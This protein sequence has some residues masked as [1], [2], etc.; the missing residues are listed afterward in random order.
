MVLSISL[1]LPV[2]DLIMDD[3]PYVV[4]STTVL[5]CISGFVYLI[6]RQIQSLNEQ[7]RSVER[8]T[9]EL[10]NR[11]ACL[12]DSDHVSIPLTE[13]Q[14]RRSSGP[15]ITY[16]DVREPKHDEQSRFK[17]SPTYR[18]WL[19]R[20]AM[21]RSSI[22][23]S[24]KPS[25]EE[26][27]PPGEALERE[28][29]K[30]DILASSLGREHSPLCSSC[31]TRLISGGFKARLHSTQENTQV[32]TIFYKMKTSAIYTSAQRGCT[33]CRVISTTLQ[34]GEEFIA[35]AKRYG[36][37]NEDC[38]D[39]K[40]FFAGVMDVLT[41]S[42]NFFGTVHCA[43]DFQME[44]R[45][46]NGTRVLSP[47]FRVFLAQGSSDISYVPDI[48]TTTECSTPAGSRPFKFIK[49]QTPITDVA[50]SVAFSQA[51]TWLEDC[52]SSHVDCS[53]QEACYMPSR[54]LDVSCENT[55]EVIKLVES[56]GL[57]GNYV[58]LSYCWGQDQKKVL[59][60]T[61]LHE[62]MEGWPV[63]SLPRT[64]QD[65]IDITRK[66][67]IRY[68][69]VDALCI[70]QDSQE[71]KKKEIAC[72]ADIF[73]NSYV[74][75]SAASAASVSDGFLHQRHSWHMQ[76]LLR[77]PLRL[78]PSDE[79]ASLVLYDGPQMWGFGS[80]SSPIEKRGWTL[81][82]K[83][84][85][86]RVLFYGT[87]HLKWMCR[88]I[89]L[90]SGSSEVLQGSF[91]ANI[92]RPTPAL[93]QS[94]NCLVS[95]RNLY[96]GWESTIMELTKRS[97]TYTEDV[98]RAVAGIAAKYQEELQDQYLAGLWKQA[99]VHELLWHGELEHDPKNLRPRPCRYIAPSWSWA[100]RTGSVMFAPYEAKDRTSD[101][102]ITDC[103]IVL[104]DDTIPFGD[105]SH[106]HITLRAPIKLA[107]LVSFAL[108][109][110]QPNID[111]L[112]G[113]VYVDS[114]ED[115]H[116]ACRQS[117]TVVSES[118]VVSCLR[119]TNDTGLVLKRTAKD[120]QTG[121]LGLDT[122]RRIGFFQSHREQWLSDCQR[123]HIAVV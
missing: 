108:F 24:E 113:T 73:S 63:D 78:C 76:P 4:L 6:L 37:N 57:A 8:I 34:D 50:S 69:W 16:S 75:V 1:A 80:K 110:I 89:P 13:K 15:S 112:E 51:K 120:E 44:I 91:L 38:F 86:R 31:T 23:A 2:L 82:E 7:L 77:I 11:V 32:F 47:N 53:R 49:T 21:M 9:T 35:Q 72:M 116:E 105:I 66:L 30:S 55:S 118:E 103:S 117:R 19:W 97:F 29:H 36:F 122:Y 115:L 25:P 43:M 18:S 109:D 107:R 93:G 20:L 111:R 65:A 67:R 87:T 28:D 79:P 90:D 42:L 94:S 85:S 68:L 59:T 48:R 123:Q 95:T 100:S 58:A 102:T 119:L 98:L 3:F 99:L 74:T 17:L 84:L 12:E 27:N 14:P 104:K 88:S 121:K 45:N 101:V 39:I 22:Q 40:A 92:Q 46:E 60:R 81:Q 70:I 5:I 83:L 54:L 64:I 106:G 96:N 33:I 56:T 114:R 26:E 41:I 52:D 61:G 71:D 10:T 62:F